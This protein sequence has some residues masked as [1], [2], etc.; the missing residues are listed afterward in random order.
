MTI[1]KN[2]LQLW[3]ITKKI[4]VRLNQSVD[5]LEKRM[6]DRISQLTDKKEIKSYYSKLK[7]Y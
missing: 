2:Y 6:N 7:F 3:K 4:I 1:F 5:I